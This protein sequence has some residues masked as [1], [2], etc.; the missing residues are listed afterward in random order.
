MSDSE[1][2]RSI[3][4]TTLS[5]HGRSIV[6]TALGSGAAPVGPSDRAGASGASAGIGSGPAPVGRRP[7]GEWEPVA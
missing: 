5:E 4:A 7:A 6:E 3:V 2:G 1:R